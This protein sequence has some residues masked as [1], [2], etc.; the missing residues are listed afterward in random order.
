MI[1]AMQINSCN[2]VRRDFIRKHIDRT[3]IEICYSIK[4]NHDFNLK[5][6]IVNER[7]QLLWF[8]FLNAAKKYVV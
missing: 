2:G 8:M 3:R 1:N 4:Q 6:Y 7:S 5:T